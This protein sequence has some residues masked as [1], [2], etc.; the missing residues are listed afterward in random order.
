MGDLCAGSGVVVEDPI[1]DDGIVC[2]PCP[3][4]WAFLVVE[5]VEPEGR[6]PRWKIVDHQEP[7]S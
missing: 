3:V 7:A 2:H 5:P 4:C 1:V 6:E